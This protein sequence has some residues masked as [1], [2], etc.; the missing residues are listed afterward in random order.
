M[1]KR[2]LDAFF[3]QR[4]W[5]RKLIGGKWELWWVDCPVNSDVWHSVPEW[6]DVVGERPTPLC[7]GTPIKEDWSDG[8]LDAREPQK[9]RL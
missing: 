7:R 4:R 6:S 3:S 2:L 9:V 1:F 8:V 5:A